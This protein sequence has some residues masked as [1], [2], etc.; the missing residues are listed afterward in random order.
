MGNRQINW[1]EESGVE[2]A[3]SSGIRG[4]GVLVGVLDTGIDA[5]H[6]E[7]CDQTVNYRYVPL[8]S[9]GG[10][11]V[12]GF[13]TEGH[14]TH[15]CGIIAGKDIGIA[16]E[17]KLYVASIIESETYETTLRRIISGL[18]WFLE[19]LSELENSEQTAVLN[20][21]LGFPSTLIHSSRYRPYLDRMR[22]V[23][24]NCVEKRDVLPIVAIGNDGK[25]EYCYPGAFKECFSVGAVDLQ[26]KI[27]NF[28]GSGI[29]EGTIKPDIV[30]YGVDIHSSLERKCEGQSIYEKMSGTSMATPYVTGIA[31]LYLCDKPQLKAKELKAKLIETAFPLSTQPPERVGVGLA[32]FVP[33]LT[34]RANCPKE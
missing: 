29:S 14:G 20:M 16:P 22:N 11:D 17:A 6:Q 33:Q 24:L 4:S 28:S 12:R 13:D 8:S 31:A 21:S 23:L 5:D 3:H 30:G 32:R 1:P 27:A 10:R 26:G 15:V 9:F 19:K 2:L 34:D 18:D 7:F 25:G